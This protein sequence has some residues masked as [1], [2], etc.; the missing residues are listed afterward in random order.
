MITPSNVGVRPL[1]LNVEDFEPAR[2][3]RSR[4]LRNAGFDV[5]EAGMATEVFAAVEERRPA[6]AIID[7][8]L[9]DADGFSLCETLKHT[10]PDLP[11]LLVS[12]IHV[13]ASAAFRGR[14]TGAAGFLR[15]PVPPDVLVS[16][17]QDALEGIRD[18][19]SLNWVVTDSAGV[20]KEASAEAAHMLGLTA[21]HLMGRSLLTFFDGDRPAWSGALTLANGDQVV[22][23]SGWVRPRD[24]RRLIVAATISRAVDYPLAKAVLWTFRSPAQPPDHS[25]R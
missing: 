18:E 16:R 12:A 17:V 6:V 19:A 2:F 15:E 22:E 8:D 9:P 7:V 14:S 13:S 25:F 4:V 23:R 3:L 1:V 11:V 20:I 5:V 24:R 21:A 10:H